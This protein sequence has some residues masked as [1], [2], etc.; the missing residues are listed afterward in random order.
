MTKVDRYCT[1]PC[2]FSQFLLSQQ[3]ELYFTNSGSLRGKM[4]GRPKKVASTF[5]T[6]GPKFVGKRKIRKWQGPFFSCGL[7]SA[8]LTFVARLRTIQAKPLTKS[9][10]TTQQSAGHTLALARTRS[11]SARTLLA[12]CSR[13][14]R[15][16]SRSLA[17]ARTLLALLTAENLGNLRFCQALGWGKVLDKIL[18]EKPQTC[19][20]A[21][22]IT[23]CTCLAL[24]FSFIH[25]FFLHFYWIPPKPCRVPVIWPVG[26]GVHRRPGFW[27]GLGVLSSGNMVTLAHCWA[28]V[29]EITLWF[30][31]SRRRADEL[32]NKD[33][34]YFLR[35]L[36]LRLGVTLT[37][38]TWS[39]KWP[40]PWYSILRKPFHVIMR[41]WRMISKVLFAQHPPQNH[42]E[43][44]SLVCHTQT[45]H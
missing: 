16:R 30:G 3:H 11:R 21:T 29:S 32:L 39:I 44:F 34:N 17:L 43:M 41:L 31:T 20:I 15:T 33:S 1:Q 42:L 13:S 8:I 26:S 25:M 36:Q 9:F 2:W 4:G 45:K 23:F 7:I 12:L 22:Q 18:K 28:R 35:G 27:P 24:K 19:K 5:R 14:A 37:C 38:S 40:P 6:Q 10:P